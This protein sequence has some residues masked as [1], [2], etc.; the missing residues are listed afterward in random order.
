METGT[1]TASLE[2]TCNRREAWW[3]E[4][5]EN[6]HLRELS[7]CV[8]L[9]CSSHS[10]WL[11]VCPLSHSISV[12]HHFSYAILSQPAGIKLGVKRAESMCTRFTG[13]S[14]SRLKDQKRPGI[15]QQETQWT[16]T[17][18]YSSVVQRMGHCGDCEE[19]GCTLFGEKHFELHKNEH[20][21]MRPFHHHLQVWN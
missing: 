9:F 10:L 6:T 1:W 2:F 14:F 18:S 5:P 3:K 21:T 20:V 17:A 4:G 8:C 13:Q 11:S 7:C 15:S 16:G 12:L 19:G